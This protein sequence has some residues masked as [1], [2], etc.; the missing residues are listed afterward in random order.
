MP[1]ILL[2]DDDRL[3][4]TTLAQGL[5]NTGYR[6]NTAESVDE[7]ES[8]LEN[9]ER[10]DLIILDVHMPGRSGLE[11]AERL[12]TLDDIPFILLTAYNDAAIVEQAAASGALSYLVKPIDVPQLIPSIEAALARAK[13]F[14]DLRDTRNQLHVALA[15]ERDISIAVGITMVQYRIDRRGAFEMLRKTARDQRRRLSEI[16]FEVIKATEM[17]SFANN[18]KK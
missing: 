4:L 14:K 2:V 13:D 3:V 7:A 10:P 18:A 15:A 1:T 11:L 6:V 12:S 17:L 8:F 16:A 5:A 9:G